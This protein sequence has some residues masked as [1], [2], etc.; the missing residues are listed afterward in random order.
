MFKNGGARS[1]SLKHKELEM[2]WPVVMSAC[3]TEAHEGL[4]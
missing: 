1:L 2:M 3:C 4:Y